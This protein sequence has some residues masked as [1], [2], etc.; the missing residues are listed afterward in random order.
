[1][2]ELEIETIKA[3][4]MPVSATIKN[5]TDKE[6]PS[7]ARIFN[8]TFRCEGLSCCDCILSF[9][10]RQSLLDLLFQLNKERENKSR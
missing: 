9:E 8:S 1:M 10:N 4:N 5:G 6:M 2:I 7:C 3:F